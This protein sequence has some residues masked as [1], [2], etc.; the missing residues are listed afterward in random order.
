[1]DTWFALGW[2]HFVTLVHDLPIDAK[3]LNAANEFV[4]YSRSVLPAN[5]AVGLAR[6]YERYP[7]CF[8]YS[9]KHKCRVLDKEARALVKRT[10]ALTEAEARAILGRVVY[11]GRHLVLTLEALVGTHTVVDAMLNGFEAFGP[12]DLAEG[13]LL[14]Y[15]TA[16]L[17]GLLLLRMDSESEAMARRRLETLF[18]RGLS[19]MTSGRLASDYGERTAVHGI[20]LS[21]HGANAAKR[22]GLGFGDFKY[23]SGAQS[24]L[25]RRMSRWTSPHGGEPDARRVFL[26][27]ATQLKTEL[28]LWSKYR[29]NY[30]D[31]DAY[32]VDTYGT[33]RSP[34][35]V[36]LM[37]DLYAR[38][39]VKGTVKRWFVEHRRYA[40]KYVEREMNGSG[41]LASVAKK[42]RRLID[43]GT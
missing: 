23:L 7:H 5:T 4:R 38:S 13:D 24:W 26:A 19:A 17:F 20:A 10:D 16:C 14:L 21:L 34:H 3:R 37:L 1:M 41:K 25:R 31:S 27:G 8:E 2:P 15:Q 35:N 33:I 36:P 11:P 29:T 42:V 6:V 22:W 39:R 28:V 30:T 43:A 18:E 32:V 12:N 40:S 9:S